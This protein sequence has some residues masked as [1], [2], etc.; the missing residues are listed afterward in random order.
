V[1]DRINA[2]DYLEDVMNNSLIDF[3]PRLAGYSNF[4][5]DATAR[6]SKTGESVT[7]TLNR[8][9]YEKALKKKK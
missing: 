2:D 5:D 4:I 7:D 3:A 6:Y 8:L 9:A 1:L